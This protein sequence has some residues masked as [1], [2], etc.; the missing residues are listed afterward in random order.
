MFGLPRWVLAWVMVLSGA[1]M[2][3]FLFLDSEGGCWIAAAFS[4]VCFFNMPMMVIRKEMTRL[5]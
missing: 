3:S 4:I 1:N 2:A 5:L